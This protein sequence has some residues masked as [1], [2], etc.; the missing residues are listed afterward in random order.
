MAEKEITIEIKN[1]EVILL[2]GILCVVLIMEL[3]VMIQQHI[4][5]GDEGFH[6]RVAQLIAKD[7]EYHVWD[8][9]HRTKLTHG[10]FSRPPLLNILLASFLF[11]SGM[12]EAII[13]FLIPFIAFLIGL[14][15]FFLGKKLYTVGLIAAIIAV[16][17]P[18]FVTYSVLVYTD[19]LVTLY[20]VMFILFFFLSL[21]G[22]NEIYWIACGVF[23]ALAFLTKTSGFAS[24]IFVFLAFVYELVGKKRVIFKKY[25]IIFLV[26]TL[27]TGS[28]FLRNYYYYKTPLCGFP[29]IQRFFDTSGC[30]IDNFEEKYKFEA[31]TEEVGTE[32]N[33]YKL[34]IMN[35]LNFAYGSRFIVLFFS[36]GLF[37]FLFDKKKESK[38]ILLMLSVFLLVLYYSASGRAEDAARYT[39]AWSPLIA[40]IAARFL[41]EIYEFIRKYKNQLAVVVFIFVLLLGYKM[42]KEKLAIMA[43]VKRFAPSFFE[44]CDWVKNN[45]PENVTITTVWSHRAAYNCQRNA[46]GHIADIFLTRNATYS[47]EVAKKLGVTHIFIQKFSLSNRAL[48]EAY[49]IDSIQFFEDNPKYFIKVFE[50]GPKWGSSELQQC[51]QTPGCDPGTIIYEINYSAV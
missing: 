43:A 33:I 26:L 47:V 11:L 51:L 25:L 12:N 40:L 17:L 38:I 46:V 21:E 2:L 28:F 50:N 35:Y 42:L 16:C 13:R 36:C 45:L 7:V 23:G 1:P 15:V 9:A 19:V 27:I 32:Q 48:S 10:G 20:M 6:A 30:M 39:L 8:P 49:K 5:F 31:R 18:S 14:A 4:V 37:L 41:E 44:A 29:Y 34:G 22:K 24:F 3:Q